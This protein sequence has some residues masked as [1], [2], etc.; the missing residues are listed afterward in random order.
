MCDKKQIP[1]SVIELYNIRP[2]PSNNFWELC[3]KYYVNMKNWNVVNFVG[4]VPFRVS[5]FCV[6]VLFVQYIDGHLTLLI[7]AI[8]FVDVHCCAFHKSACNGCNKQREISKRRNFHAQVHLSLTLMI[9]ILFH[10]FWFNCFG[11]VPGTVCTQCAFMP[12]RFMPEHSF[13][14]YSKICL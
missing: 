5:Y 8:S 3:Y 6:S 7:K 11:S 14:G 1:L 4:N 12:L 2:F 9:L 10:F 13:L